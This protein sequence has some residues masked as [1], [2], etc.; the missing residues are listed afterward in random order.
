[1]ATRAV[2]PEI[3]ISSDKMHAFVTLAPPA[4]NEPKYTVD[5]IVDALNEKKVTYGIE[6]DIIKN[7]IMSSTYSQTVCVANGKPVMEGSDGYYLYNFKEKGSLKPE[8]KPD[9]SV[10]Y[11]SVDLIQIVK[12]GEVVAEYHSAVQGS[13]GMDVSGK[14]L[15]AKRKKDL[16]PLKGRGFT[17][18]DD[19]GI[20]I[21][22][23]DGKIDFQR[24]HLVI[25]PVYEVKGN[26]DIKTGNIDFPGDV[27]IHGNAIAGVT[28]KANESITI[29]G[30]VENA[31]LIAGKDVIIRQGVKGVNKTNIKA[32]GSITSKYIEFANV[33]AGGN[34]ETDSIVDSTIVA[35]EKVILN[36]K[37]GTIIGGIVSAVSG[38]ETKDLGS[39]SE[40]HTFVHVG[41]NMEVFQRIEA[42]R[43][44]MAVTQKNIE[45]IGKGIAE[46]DR[47]IAKNES[48]KKD[49]PRRMQLL[50][51][52][53]RDT[54]LLAA[55]KAEYD[56]LNA[57]VARGAGATV[58]VLNTVYPGVEIG[59]GPY[60]VRV[61]EYR[62]NVE[63]VRENE[64]IK[65]KSL[66]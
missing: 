47:L 48:I 52:K 56:N 39:E 4:F 9:G 46:F 62:Q 10:D 49:D 20:Y 41:T 32:R 21:S 64:T 15:L 34:I 22:D 11:W 25:S 3:T 7:M 66:K 53:I 57:I 43:K 45:K 8:E 1:M 50:K 36:G 19:L 29:D 23:V 2:P 33:E 17:R 28:I 59:I 12:K 30:V 35:G 18:D 65:M 27:V 31:N 61:K 14:T 24:D 55:D 5:E 6:M 40:I 26:A 58:Y 54:A 38:I 13:D 60:T 42:L 37:Y 44:K 51:V 16:S 63:F